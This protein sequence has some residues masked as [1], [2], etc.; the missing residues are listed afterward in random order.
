M[1]PMKLCFTF[2]LL[3]LRLCATDLEFAPEKRTAAGPGKLFLAAKNL[4]T[5]EALQM[6]GTG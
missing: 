3:A 5:G 4:K 2:S 6:R 1:A